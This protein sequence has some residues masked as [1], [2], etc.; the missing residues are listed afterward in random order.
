MTV[1]L[2][3][4]DTIALMRAQHCDH[5]WEK[6]NAKEDRCTKCGVAATPEGRQHLAAAYK[7]FWGFEPSEA[8][9]EPACP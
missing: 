2:L 4:A 9:P 3:V 6:L 8:P 5:R 7:R 1:G